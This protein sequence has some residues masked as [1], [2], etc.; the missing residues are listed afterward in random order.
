MEVRCLY[1]DYQEEKFEIYLFTLLYLFIQH[2]I[3]LTNSSPNPWIFKWPDNT[4]LS[5]NSSFW[6]SGR[7]TCLLN[8]IYNKNKLIIQLGQPNNSGGNQYFVQEPSV[9]V[10]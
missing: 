2:K 8:V 5:V 3:G 1:V 4:Q 7:V 10:Q 9:V 6:C